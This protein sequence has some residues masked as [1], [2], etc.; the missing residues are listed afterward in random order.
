MKAVVSSF[1][2]LAEYIGKLAEANPGGPGIDRLLRLAQHLSDELENEAAPL[3]A[4]AKNV[5]EMRDNQDKYV[6]FVRAKNYTVAAEYKKSVTLFQN[7]VDVKTQQII[8][9]CR[10]GKLF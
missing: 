6:K 4:Y 7:Q 1:N 2:N 5:K 9:G 3:I 8:T 10:P